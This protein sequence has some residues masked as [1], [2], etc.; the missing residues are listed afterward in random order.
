[1]PCLANSIIR[2][3]LRLELSLVLLIIQR[4]TPLH[5]NIVSVDD[6][7]NP[8]ESC[9]FQG[10]VRQYTEIPPIIKSNSYAEVFLVHGEGERLTVSYDG[11]RNSKQVYAKFGERFDDS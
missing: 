3:H 4:Y 9:S 8:H 5:S 10:G 11:K 1:M 7:S 2:L 6:G